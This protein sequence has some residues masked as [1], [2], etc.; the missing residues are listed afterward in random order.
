[1]CA[2]HIRV[3]ALH[4]L[5]EADFEST[6]LSPKGTILFLEDQLRDLLPEVSV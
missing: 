1:M 3:Q 2:Y 6:K 5:E 4:Q